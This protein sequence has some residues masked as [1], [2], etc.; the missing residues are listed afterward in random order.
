MREGKKA[1]AT[2]KNIRTQ[3]PCLLPRFLKALIYLNQNFYSKKST[4]S[5]NLLEIL[6][7]LNK[8]TKNQ[9]YFFTVETK[10]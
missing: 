9:L 10:L 7:K 5:P 1:N 2:S 6:K 8:M 3:F 4:Q